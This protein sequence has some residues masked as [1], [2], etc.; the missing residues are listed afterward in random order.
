MKE[1]LGF[2][3]NMDY[4]KFN[5]K[6]KFD[7]KEYQNY[8]Q[9]LK[10]C[11]AIEI[12]HVGRY[13]KY[14]IQRERVK[15]AIKIVHD[16]EM[17]AILYSGIFGTEDIRNNQNFVKY[18]QK[19][20]EGK[21]LSYGDMGEITAM[22]CPSSEYVKQV[23]IPQ[24]N[25]TLDYANY[26]GIFLD[27]PW[28][29]YGGCFCDNCEPIRKEDKGNAEIVR[30]GL[31]NF[32]QDIKKSFPNVKI[33][34]NASA[35][36]IYNHDYHGAEM[37]NLANLFDEY[38]TE[39]NPFRFNQNVQ[40]VTRCITKAKE[41]SSGKFYHATTCTDGK[42]KIYSA[43]KLGTLFSAILKGGASPRL[44][45]AF[46]IHQLDIIKE[47]WSLALENNRM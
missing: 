32:V 29:M 36:T 16:L 12:E 38:V 24:I 2:R 42:R 11:G 8:V 30:K 7:L 41:L 26:D 5:F 27:I 1:K 34:V 6:R 14:P 10:E 31:E 39:W 46:P 23:V 9:K 37:E 15:E 25:H 33:S 19:N 4:S 40:T 43:K 13:L 22:M 28:I 47:A 21:I 18:A 45:V 35:P 44:G 20:K 3:N 17:K